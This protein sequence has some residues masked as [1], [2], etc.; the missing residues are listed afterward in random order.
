[1]SARVSR[2]PIDAFHLPGLDP[3]GVARWRVREYA[4]GVSLRFPQ[5]EPAQLGAVIA[6]LRE[7]RARFLAD[8]PADAIAAAIAAAAARLGRDDDAR[9]RTALDALPAVTGYSPPMVRLV[10]DRMLEDW[11]EAS[12]REL[13]RSEFPDPGVLDGFRPHPAGRSGS[14]T[15]AL[16]PEL[17]FHIFAG[18]VPGVAVTSIVRSLLVKAATL[19][20]TASG[21][22]LLPVLFARTL[23]AVDSGLG[24]CLAVT[25]WPGGSEDLEAVA[26]EA[27]DAV[28]VYGG[29]GV[30]EDVRRRAPAGRRVVVHGPRFSLGLVGRD[31]L[32]AR[33]AEETAAQAARAVA[34]FD[35]QGCVSPHLY[36]VEEGGETPPARFAERL[37]AHLARLQEDLPRGAISPAE[38]AAIQT[39]RADAEARALAGADVQ[40]YAARGTEFTVIYDPDPAFAPSPLNRVVRVKPL[41]DLAAAVGLI[42]PL[43]HLI[44]TVGVAGA[45]GRLVGL[46]EALGRAGAPRITSLARMP[47]PPPTGHHDGQEPLRELVRWVDLEG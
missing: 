27:A 35:Q 41:A 10:L 26:L 9:R 42:R 3:G 19:G 44:Q 17:A 16:G 20:K 11:S 37:A 24:E 8:R 18:N 5:L 25:Y 40:V 31:A 43:A 29:A 13:L 23:A 21:E 33:R 47:W 32:D 2:P 36:Y 14:R 22:P 7:S 39:A 28:I 34:I 45:G 46:A 30:A 15:R 4:G 12:L 38:A 6:H 1:V